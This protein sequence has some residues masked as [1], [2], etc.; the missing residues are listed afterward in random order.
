MDEGGV[1]SKGDVIIDEGVVG[2]AWGTGG[3]VVTACRSDGPV[4][5][6]EEE[7]GIGEASNK[8]RGESND[9]KNDLTELE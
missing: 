3:D 7:F 8:S 2:E 4:V 9:L 6:V 1:G 5:F